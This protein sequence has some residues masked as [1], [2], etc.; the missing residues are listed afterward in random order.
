[1]EGSDFMGLCLTVVCC[2]RLY[3]HHIVCKCFYFI[4]NRPPFC[5]AAGSWIVGRKPFSFFFKFGVG[6]KF[7]D[8]LNVHMEVWFVVFWLSLEKF[9]IELLLSVVE[10]MDG[11][12]YKFALKTDICW[13]IYGKRNL[14]IFFFSF[15]V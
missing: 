9:P 14:C 4:A 10:N 7:F 2:G 15:F 3:H 11:L 1:M 12:L 8:L 13:W 5:F 6:N